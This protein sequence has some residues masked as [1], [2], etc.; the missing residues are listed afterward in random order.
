[1]T[2]L[3]HYELLAPLFAY[4]EENFLD[5]VRELRGHLEGHYPG[6]AADFEH[7]VNLLPGD[8]TTLSREGLSEVQDVFTRSFEVQSVATLDV[9]YVAF[10]DDYKRGELLVNLNRE[11]HDLGIDAGVELSDHLSNVLRLMG[12]W[13]DKETMTELVAM[14][15]HPAVEKMLSEFGPDRTEARNVLYKKHYKTLIESSVQRATIYRHALATLLSVIRTDFK[16]APTLKTETTSDFLASLTRELD[17]EARGEGQR[18]TPGR[19]P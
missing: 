17:I 16:L 1:M 11:L 9:G 2:T 5:R 8:G 12:K 6:A 13:E 7:F 18:P 15:L 10:G 4:P 14:V 19:T 3:A